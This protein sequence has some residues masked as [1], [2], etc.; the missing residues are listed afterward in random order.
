MLDTLIQRVKEEVAIDGETGSNIND[1]WEY[2]QTVLKETATQSNTSITPLVDERYKQFIWKYLVVESDLSFYE[3]THDVTMNQDTTQPEAEANTLDDSI[4]PIAKEQTNASTT[5][6]QQSDREEEDALAN[7]K[8]KRPP[9]KNKKKKATAKK[10]KKKPKKKVAAGDSDDDFVDDDMS[11]SS[12]ES[13]F[14]EVASSE[15][16]DGEEDVEQLLR[17][18]TPMGQKR[19]N[20]YQKSHPKTIEADQQFRINKHDLILIQNIQQFSYQEV[21]EK[22]GNRLF[23]IASDKLQEE[24]LLIDVPPGNILSSNLLQVLKEILKTRKK[25]LYQANIT[26]LLQLD[27]RSTGHYVKSLEEKGAI[28][29]SGVSI[30]SMYTNICVHVRFHA[31]KTKLDMNTVGDDKESNQIPYNVNAFG[32]VYSQQMVLES[33]VEFAQGAP[34]NIVI[35]RDV[36]HALVSC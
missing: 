31:E 33:F 2:V 16:E 18:N 32:K 4:E 23:V 13:E 11:E 25:G 1:V 26:K 19:N 12:S 5:E 10:P 14:D 21:V 36:L 3:S 24:Q 15:E 34:N 9:P 17:K 29:R 22:Y 35:A 20:S 6:Q 28:T 8:R 7:K 27:S 30:N